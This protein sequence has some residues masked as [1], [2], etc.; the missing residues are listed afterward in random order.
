VARV[1]KA[2]LDFATSGTVRES[3]RQSQCAACFAGKS[4][5]WI[6][7]L[8]LARPKNIRDSATFRADKSGPFLP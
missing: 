3:M 2:L 7:V 4:K 5:S 1:F 6:P 8:D